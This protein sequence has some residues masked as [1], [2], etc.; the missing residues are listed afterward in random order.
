VTDRP[1][2][3]EYVRSLL[4]LRLIDLWASHAGLFVVSKHPKTGQQLV[5]VQP[6]FKVRY[7]VAAHA[8]RLAEAL[9]LTP[10]TRKGMER[11]AGGLTAAIVALD[12]HTQED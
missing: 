10:A 5:D 12:A 4:F 3:D 2:V 7:T 9:Q 6:V 8:R 1:L 11:Q